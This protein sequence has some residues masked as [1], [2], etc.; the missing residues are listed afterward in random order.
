M[1]V[2][3]RLLRRAFTRCLVVHPVVRT[4]E[5]PRV[6]EEDVYDCG[7]AFGLVRSLGWQA[8]PGP[9]R[10]YRFCWEEPP[11]ESGDDS[12]PA[13]EGATAEAG[14][15]V[16]TDLLG[17]PAIYAG[18]NY[19]EILPE[20]EGEDER[21]APR[22][23]WSE[24][25]ENANVVRLQ[26]EQKL[27]FF[28]RADLSGLGGF[29]RSTDAQVLFVNAFL[30]H[31]QLRNIKRRID[32]TATPTPRVVLDRLG[33]ILQ[34]F[35]QRSRNDL[36]RLQVALV[37]LQYLRTHFVREDDLLVSLRDVQNFDILRPAESR[38]RIISAKQSGFRGATGGEGEQELE[39]QR[40][41]AKNLEAQIKE[42]VRK[43]ETAQKA[44]VQKR[45]SNL[46]T[47][48][49]VGYT[50]AGKSALM[51]RFAGGE[52]VESK[53]MLFQTLY[54]VK[55]RVVFKGGF[56]VQLIDTIGFI[57]NLP[58]EMVSPFASTLETVRA[59][60]IVLHIRDVSHPQTERQKK[61]VLSVLDSLGLGSLH[62]EKKLIEVRNK[63]DL[64]R[65]KEGS[66]AVLENG[67]DVM[68]VS[69]KTGE[70]IQL[71]KDCIKSKVYAFFGC[72]RHKFEHAPGVHS[73]IVSW[74]RE[75]A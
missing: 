37:Y 9:F 53:D 31:I 4:R 41:Q 8:L 36:A 70:G 12:A 69:A 75:F 33:V 3:R 66:S 57:S 62:G 19:Y 60:D 58:T 30:S 13:A 40:R 56:D 34:I 65:A 55:K 16:K 29:M 21:N 20:E 42:R 73:E 2:P 22:G 23:K 50:N 7:E 61:T 15:G 43:A 26:R 24:L 52:V 59:A 27:F 35:N 44:Q 18:S 6:A 28:N 11:A 5:K 32:E 51:N 54:T 38:L 45:P 1:L 74:L 71:L 49:L 14:V 47:V 39:L 64:L 63:I 10:H 72:F 48:A 67:T 17:F 68:H 46:A 25:P